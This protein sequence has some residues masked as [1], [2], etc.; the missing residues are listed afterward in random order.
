MRVLLTAAIV[1]LLIQP[2][3]SQ[4]KPTFKMGGDKEVDP[5]VEQYRKDIEQEY[6]STL[7]RIPNKEKKNKNDPWAD[8][9]D[10]EVTKKQPR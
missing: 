2:A 5:R 1:V 9:R 8:M 10:S 7:N 3:Y 6:K 4:L